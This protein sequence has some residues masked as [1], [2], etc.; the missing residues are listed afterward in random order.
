LKAE[1]QITGKIFSA[2]V[3]LRMPALISASSAALPSTNFLKQRVVEFGN[4][5]DHLLAVFRGLF[6]QI[7]GNRDHV[8]LRAQRLIAPDARPSS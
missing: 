5:F 2:M 8:E 1:P 7:G 3:A 4:R 6:E